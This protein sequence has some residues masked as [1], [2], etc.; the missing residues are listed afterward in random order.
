MPFCLPS[1]PRLP[2]RAFASL[3][4]LLLAFAVSL[5][6]A[7]AQWVGEGHRMPAAPPASVV[8][9]AAPKPNCRYFPETGHNLCGAFL[10]YW[11]T[12]GG[13]LM[14]GYPLTE[15]YFAPELGDATHNGVQTQWF[16]RTRLE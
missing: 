7:A 10:R 11:E 15:E 6:H 2:G 14:F 1:G 5:P 3:L 12:Y 16:E 13:L 4:A 8:A 9:P